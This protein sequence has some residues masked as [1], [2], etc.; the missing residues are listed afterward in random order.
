MFFCNPFG[1]E[2]QEV[3]EMKENQDTCPQC[4]LSIPS[5]AP[6]GGGLLEE[7]DMRGDKKGESVSR[8]RCCPVVA[9][10]TQSYTAYGCSS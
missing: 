2:G 7:S 5:E 9:S 8:I 10:L 4:G 6:G 3:G 1:V